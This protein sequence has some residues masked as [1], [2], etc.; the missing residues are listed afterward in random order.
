VRGEA[1]KRQESDGEKENSL[2]RLVV[3]GILE[4]ISQYSEGKDYWISINSSPGNSAPIVWKPPLNRPPNLGDIDSDTVC[5]SGNQYTGFTLYKLVVDNS[6]SCLRI[7][8]VENCN[9]NFCWAPSFCPI[10]RVIW[11]LWPCVHAC[12]QHTL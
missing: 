1:S 4:K 2:H 6:L 8:G 5:I 9:A 7:V 3:V 12:R 10:N 11:Y